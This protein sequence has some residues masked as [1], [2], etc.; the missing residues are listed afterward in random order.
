MKGSANSLSTGL[1]GS[2]LQL[3]P[4]AAAA[5]P[6]PVLQT[7]RLL[8]VVDLLLS[9][10]QPVLL[11]GEAATGKS[12]FVEALVAPQH[13][14]T[15][16]PIHPAVRTTHLRF[17]LSQGVQGPPQASPW[18]AQQD[19]KGCILFLLEDLHLAASGEELGGGKRSLSPLETVKALAV[20]T[21]SYRLN[22]SAP[23]STSP[24]ACAPS[25]ALSLAGPHLPSLCF[26]C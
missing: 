14:Y 8:Y 23:F 21:D 24:S 17:L 9:E 20:F 1:L 16:S 15:C 10:G 7:E 5:S 22:L 4:C 3:A 2:A 25:V 11:A 18:P 19:S 12:A 6:A 26:D 13:P